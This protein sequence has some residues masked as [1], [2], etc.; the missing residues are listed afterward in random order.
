[1]NEGRGV[2]LDD[3]IVQRFHYDLRM[4]S[5]Y[6]ER[7]ACENEGEYVRSVWSVRFLPARGKHRPVLTE[8]FEKPPGREKRG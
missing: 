1:M 8:K 2:Y 3:A 6:V 5:R 4:E 7:I